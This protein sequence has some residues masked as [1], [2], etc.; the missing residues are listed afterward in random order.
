MWGGG[1]EVV[2]G[3]SVSNR[4][5]EELRLEESKILKQVE[6]EILLVVGTELCQATVK[7]MCI[8]SAQETTN[9]VK[10]CVLISFQTATRFR[11]L[12][13]LITFCTIIQQP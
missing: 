4:S 3:K 13:Y 2:M 5:F 7:T 12:R 8:L 10:N 6:G 1:T 11:A 9:C